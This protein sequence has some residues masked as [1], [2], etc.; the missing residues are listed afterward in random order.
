MDELTA[1]FRVRFLAASKLVRGVV[2]IHALCADMPRMFPPDKIF[3]IEYRK[4]RLPLRQRNQQTELDWF[5]A[6][7]FNNEREWVLK[8]P[9]AAKLAEQAGSWIQL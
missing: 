1:E 7:L 4:Y 5:L 9:Y 6:R 2:T 8:Q 3:T